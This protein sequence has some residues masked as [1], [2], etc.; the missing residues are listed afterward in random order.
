MMKNDTETD[1]SVRGLGEISQKVI[2]ET[3][4]ELARKQGRESINRA[5]LIAA[6]KQILGNH[7]RSSDS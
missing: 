7:P 5:D 4:R 3:A 2:E 6:E 1:R